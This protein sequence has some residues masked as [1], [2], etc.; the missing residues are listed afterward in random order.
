MVTVGL[1]GLAP[2]TML[3]FGTSV[4]LDEDAV[5]VTVSPFESE[6]ERFIVPIVPPLPLPRLHIP[7][8]TT[9]MVGGWL[10]VNV[11][12]LSVLVE[13]VLALPA[14]SI[15]APAGIEAVTVPATVIPLTATL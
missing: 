12:V 9:A 1:A 11:T 3:A 14:P 10:T 4:V 13:A 8:R 15:A 6:T 5:S 2:N 7:P